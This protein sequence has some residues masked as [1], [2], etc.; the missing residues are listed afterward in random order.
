MTSK[1]GAEVNTMTSKDHD[2]DWVTALEEC[3]LPSEFVQLRRMAKENT[4]K[5]KEAI[6]NLGFNKNG[7][8]TFVIY[9]ENEKHVDFEL[10][11]NHIQVDGSGIK[12]NFKLTLAPNDK[13]E[14]RYRVDD[15]EEEFLRWQ[16][17]KKALRDLLFD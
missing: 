16:I 11:R 12:D 7:N 17:M 10:C 4:E 3:S 14:C 13:G 9:R 5:R 6:S 1:K 15:G 8:N 2:F